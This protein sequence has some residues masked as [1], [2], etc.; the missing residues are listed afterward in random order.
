VLLLVGIFGEYLLVVGAFEDGLPVDAEE[1]SV[2]L[3]A[4]AQD[5]FSVEELVHY[6]LRVPKVAG[7]NVGHAV[8]YS[9]LELAIMHLS[10]EG[11]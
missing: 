7:K 6:G 4:S 5:P 8:D 3:A 9:P 10:R 1:V 2:V 11:L